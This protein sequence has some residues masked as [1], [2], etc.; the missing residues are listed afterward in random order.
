MGSLRVM[1][2][3]EALCCSKCYSHNVFLLSHSKHY[4]RGIL[5]IL[6]LDK[7]AENIQQVPGDVAVSQ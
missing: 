7:C 6:L 2:G 3:G 5:I 4:H 1:Q